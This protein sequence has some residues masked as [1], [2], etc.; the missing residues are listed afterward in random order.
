MVTVPDVKGKSRSDAVAVLEKA[1]FSVEYTDD[2]FS[3]DVE[4]GK[5]CK[6]DPEGN[7]KAAKGSTV[8][9]T[10]SKGVESV[11]V[12]DVSGKTESEARSIL[13][14][15]EFKVSVSYEESDTVEKGIVISQNPGSGSKANKGSQI[16]L[17]VSS[18]SDMISMPSV[19]GMSPSDA[20]AMLESIGLHVQIMGTGTSKV[21]S[22]SVSAG[23]KVKKGTTVILTVS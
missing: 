7:T 4:A 12:P 15:A 10:I 20:Q 17:K 13:E 18:G 5:I 14:A 23:T 3:T 16:T 21:V 22:Q 1:G 11:S 9:I 2:E 6:Q 8:K 19:I